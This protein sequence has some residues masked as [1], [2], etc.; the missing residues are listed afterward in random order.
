MNDHLVKVFNLNKITNLHT[1]SHHNLP[2][3]K[4][5]QLLND[6]NTHDQETF[7]HSKEVALLSLWIGK[8]CLTPQFYDELYYGA[9]LHDIGKLKWN[10]RLLC[11]ARQ[12]RE[13]EK[14][15]IK[16][17]PITGYNI[18]KEF[19]HSSI[20]K[21]IILHHHENCDGS[22]YPNE[23]TFADLSIFP[24]IVRIADTICAMT[25]IRYYR[26]PPKMSVFD[27]VKRMED[28]VHC[29]DISLF[30]LIKQHLKSDLQ[31]K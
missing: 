15:M 20:I 6:L 5:K 12:L 8:Q 7:T 29:F 26:N 21:D 14:Q 30:S 22:G 1:N 10:Q 17:H 25:R 24:R 23:L 28:F 4:F 18:I 31:L 9:L 19:T 27:A 3:H 16:E 13:Y 11:G 2:I